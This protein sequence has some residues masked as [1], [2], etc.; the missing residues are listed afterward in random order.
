MT[1]KLGCGLALVVA[2][3]MATYWLAYKLAEHF[4]QPGWVGMVILFLFI[5]VFGG[6]TQ[7]KRP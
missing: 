4:G 3:G 2:S 6:S 7:A 1:K 5:A